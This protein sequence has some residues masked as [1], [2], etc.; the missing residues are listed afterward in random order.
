[1]VIPNNSSETIKLIDIIEI[2]DLG[3]NIDPIKEQLNTLSFGYLYKIECEK[4]GKV[5]QN[6]IQYSEIFSTENKCFLLMERYDLGIEYQKMMVR[7]FILQLTK[8]MYI[9]AGELD[10]FGQYYLSCYISGK[11][12]NTIGK[13]Q[14]EVIDNRA[15]LRENLKDI[16]SYNMGISK[17]TIIMKPEEIS[18]LTYRT[19]IPE[20]IAFR[21]LPHQFTIDAIDGREFNV[22]K[23]IDD[24]IE[25]KIFFAIEPADNFENICQKLAVDIMNYL[26]KDGAV[27]RV[28]NNN[29]ICSGTIGL[30][31]GDEILFQNDPKQVFLVEGSNADPLRRGNAIKYIDEP[32][33]SYNLKVI[34]IRLLEYDYSEE[35]D[36]FEQWTHKGKTLRSIFEEKKAKWIVPIEFDLEAEYY[37]NF[38]HLKKDA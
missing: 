29:K 4:N 33:N 28:Y 26:S 12:N 27:R 14:I 17:L 8:Y 25:G 21:R 9:R 34:T 30:K 5:E 10:F 7:F 37:E 31:T 18:C 2:D 20:I 23:N 19:N 38:P 15:V 36:I 6:L 22:L 35:T 11:S 24:S 13:I 16:R 1:M 3:K 32:E